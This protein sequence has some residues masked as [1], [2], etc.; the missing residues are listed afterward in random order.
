MTDKAESA[1]ERRHRLIIVEDDDLMRTFYTSL[2]RRHKDE[3]ACLFTRNAEEALG[4]LNEENFHAVLLDWDLPGLSGLDLL[5]AIR[6]HPRTKAIPV[7]IVSGRTRTEDQVRALSAGADDYLTKP[8]E[9]EIL[10]A[11][12]RR[13]LRR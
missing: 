11:R 6:A 1:A 13:L 2:F 10:L 9:V 8:F 12:L 4:K 7:F 5:K 3:F